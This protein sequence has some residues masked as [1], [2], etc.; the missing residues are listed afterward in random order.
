MP[1][2]FDEATRQGV[3]RLWRNLL[4]NLGT[5][6]GKGLAWFIFGVAFI[7]VAVWALDMAWDAFT[8][9]FTGAWS[10]APGHGWLGSGTAEYIG[11]PTCG[12]AVM[13]SS[14]RRSIQLKRSS[15]RLLP[16]PVP[17]AA[18]PVTG[19]GSANRFNFLQKAVCA[20]T[21]PFYLSVCFLQIPVPQLD[22]LFLK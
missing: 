3:R 6:L 16:K 8:S 15:K 4:S 5:H 18:E 7:L 20:S 12:P 2:S 21:L 14:A 19:T 1:E 22:S 11:R 17:F 13:L 9:P 10:Q